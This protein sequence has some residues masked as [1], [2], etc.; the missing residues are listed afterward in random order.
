MRLPSDIAVPA[1][2]RPVVDREDFLDEPSVSS[3]TAFTGCHVGSETSR[4][5][6]VLVHRPGAELERLVPD[7]HRGFLFDEIPWLPEAQREHDVFTAALRHQEVNAGP[8]KVLDVSPLAVH[9]LVG[10]PGSG[11]GHEFTLVEDHQRVTG[12]PAV[13]DCTCGRRVTGQQLPRRLSLSGQ[14]APVTQGVHI[15]RQRA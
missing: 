8:A 12:T 13:L 3:L 15:L 10:V 7:N 4:L 11:E 2:S 9:E 6:R 14:A 1:H 5:R